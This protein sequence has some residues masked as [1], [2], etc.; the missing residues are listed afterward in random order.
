MFV[1]CCSGSNSYHGC[2]YYVLMMQH[3]KW[4]APDIT[5][6]PTNTA[7]HSSFK[8]DHCGP[9]A[10]E[11]GGGNEGWIMAK[12]EQQSE[13]GLGGEAGREVVRG[14]RDGMMIPRG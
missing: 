9:Y 14:G 7:T 12:R 11:C 13:R 4:R 8:V 3:S 5:A 2:A 6:F 1:V 10:N